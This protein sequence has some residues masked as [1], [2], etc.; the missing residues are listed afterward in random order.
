MLRESRR[1]RRPLL[2]LALVFCLALAACSDGPRR[3]ASGSYTVRAGDTLYSIAWRHGLDYH[4]LARLNHIGR[5]YAISVGQTLQLSAGTTLAAAVPPRALPA[6][7]ALPA[8]PVTPA[9]AWLWP[10]DGAVV[11]TR[12]QPTGG[13]GLEIAADAGAAVRAAANGRV[14]Y[15]GA[16][17]RGYGE[18]VIVKHDDAWLTA[19]GYNRDVL[20]HEGD[21]VGV[22]QRIASVGAGPGGRPLLYFEIRLNGRPV[23]PLAQLPARR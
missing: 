17:L 12:R 14:V 6:A 21:S 8:L 4:E 18:L 15:R 23:D 22:G 3:S 1:L 13:L 16:G 20:V 5:D 10:A 11:T 7:P 9:P 2:R 19:Y